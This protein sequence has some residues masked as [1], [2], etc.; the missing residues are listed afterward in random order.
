MVKYYDINELNV[1]LNNNDESELVEYKSN[2]K[3]PELIG[4]YISAL[5]NSSIILHNRLSY[6][7]WGIDDNTKETKGTDFKP[8]TAKKGGMPLVTF[9]EK[10]IDPRLK[11]EWK[12]F[13]TE[14]NRIVVSLIINTEFVSKPVAFKGKRYIRS[15]SSLCPL[16]SFPEKERDI[17]R[18]F[19]SNKFELQFAMEELTLN[20]VANLIDI[21]FYKNNCLSPNAN[22][23]LLVKSLINDKILVPTGEKFN[24]TNLGAYTLATDLNNFPNILNRT[25][26]IV[27]YNG[28]NSIENAVYDRSGFLGIAISF[29]NIL[30]NIMNQINYVEKY[31]GGLRKEVPPF[32]EIAIR[33]LVANALVHQDFTIHG[34]RPMI[35]IFDNRIEISNPGVP[36]I[37]IPRFL[38]FKPQSR[39]E[40][41]ANLLGKFHIVESRGTG[42]D[43]AVNSL[44]KAGLPA[45]EI[46][47]QND[48]FTQVKLKSIKKYNELSITEKLNI[49]YWHACLNMVEGKKIDNASI[50]ERFKLNKN[51]NNEISKLIMQALEEKLIKIY[52]PKAGQRARQYIPFWAHG[53]GEDDKWF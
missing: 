14:T 44:E 45:P 35:E 32:P 36:I 5:A 34:S 12:Y 15:G 24:I 23:S 26:R 21:N 22:P 42:I 10:M 29:K 8:E 17:W 38:D 9:L 16:D 27:K 52:D 41:L 49:I 30:K 39:N 18:S 4:K 1:F 11:L 31:E 48:K 33:E 19:D 50:R 2:L 13:K 3:D 7:I 20:E 43:K 47:N 28:N 51:K 37:P 46:E 53:L 25:I 40:E 6:L